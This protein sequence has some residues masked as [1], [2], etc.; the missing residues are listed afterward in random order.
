MSLKTA[1]MEKES[2]KLG[3]DEEWMSTKTRRGCRWVNTVAGGRQVVE[4][5][6]P[7]LGDETGTTFFSQPSTATSHPFSSNKFYQDQREARSVRSAIALRHCA[8][9]SYD[10]ASHGVVQQCSRM[11]AFSGPPPDGSILHSRITIII[12]SQI[13]GLSGVKQHQ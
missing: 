4:V 8:S 13:K 6:K 10:A 3:I 9:S 12:K 11:V 5:K 7:N 2:H 1:T